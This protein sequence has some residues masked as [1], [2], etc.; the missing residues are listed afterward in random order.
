MNRPASIQELVGGIRHIYQSDVSGAE[1]LIEQYLQGA[2]KEFNPS[3]RL[4]LLD[5]LTQEFKQAFP[6]GGFANG[7]GQDLVPKL[8]SLFLG[9]KVDKIDLSSGEFLERLAGSLNTVFE[10]LNEIIAVINAT[11]LGKQAELKTIRQIIGKDLHD[12][13]GG[14][15][16]EDHLSQ[17]KKAFLT[18]HQAFKQAA[19]TKV[20]EI[21]LELDPDRIA[22]SEAG[23]LK[24]GPLKKAG[25]FDV[26]QKRFQR[27]RNWFESDRF[28][29][30]LLRE[31]EKTCQSFYK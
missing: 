4:E 2:L 1:T 25:C 9:K 20:N 19:R 31:F 13:I 22:D 15:S 6:P 28:T 17:I 23:G 8:F 26:Y 14:T 21:L 3:D 5:R 11:L 29:E 24:L 7:P 12:E 27:V 18:S 16:L 30:E 10:S